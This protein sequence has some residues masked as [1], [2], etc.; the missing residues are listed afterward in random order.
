MEIFRNTNFDF[1]GKKWWFIGASLVLTVIGFASIA[2]KGG[3]RYGIDFKGGSLMTV[4][5]AGQPPVDRI[6]AALG[7]RISGEI[8]VYEL[9]DLSDRNLVVLGTEIREERALSADTRV[10]QETLEASFGQPGGKLDF[11]N[12]SQQQLIDRLREPFQRASIGM[13]DQQL[14]KLV[15][16][17]VEF[18]I[19]PPRSGLLGSLDQLTAVPGINSGIIN[20]LKQEC[21]LAPFS[22]R[23]VEMVGPKVGAEL[24]QRAVFATLYRWPECWYI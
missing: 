4:K 3:L 10:M 15:A 23:Q 18:R 1:L 12:A 16:D 22:V 13:S 19:T 5:W 17:M 24:R 2:L 14:Q 9:N 11:S 6:R 8:T 20:I 7:K 21:Y